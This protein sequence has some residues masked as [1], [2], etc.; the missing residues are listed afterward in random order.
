MHS[1]ILR[2]KSG[3]YLATKLRIGIKISDV[4]HKKLH[5]TVIIK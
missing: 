1:N 2:K 3:K 4:D 5:P